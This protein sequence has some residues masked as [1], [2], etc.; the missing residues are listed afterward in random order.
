MNGVKQSESELRIE[1]DF[2]LKYATQQVDSSEPPAATRHLS[3]P[4]MPL[5]GEHHE[6]LE[7]SE[8]APLNGGANVLAQPVFASLQNPAKSV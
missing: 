3:Q 7:S 4:A 1:A 6:D 2:R 8:T 5:A